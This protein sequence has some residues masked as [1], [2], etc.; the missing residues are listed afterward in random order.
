MFYQIYGVTFTEKTSLKI[1]KNVKYYKAKQ[2]YGLNF[3][4]HGLKFLTPVSKK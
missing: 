4:A 2:R 1:N 3:L